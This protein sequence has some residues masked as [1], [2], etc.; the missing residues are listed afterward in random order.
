MNKLIAEYKDAAE[1]VERLKNDFH[2]KF[3]EVPSDSESISR[4]RRD[5]EFYQGLLEEKWLEM[6]K[7]HSDIKRA[8]R[9]D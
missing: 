7:L 6:D 8:S 9:L 2:S 5:Y 1:H 3:T 4:M